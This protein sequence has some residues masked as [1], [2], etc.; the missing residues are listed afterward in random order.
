MTCQH[1]AIE[2]I[3]YPL[4]L[5]TGKGDYHIATVYRANLSHNDE[6][7]LNQDNCSLQ[8]QCQ[9]TLTL[10]ATMA[11]PPRPH[12]DIMRPHNLQTNTLVPKAT[13][14]EADLTNYHKTRLT[15]LATL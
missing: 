10:A 14:K 15:V 4:R 9:S 5:G 1:S 6:V 12:S 11:K 3:E 7:V 2:S 13:S 8:Q